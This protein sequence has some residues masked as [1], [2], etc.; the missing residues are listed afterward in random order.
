MPSQSGMFGD[1][2]GQRRLPVVDVTNGSNV[3][4]R[5]LP[6]KFLLSHLFYS[7]IGMF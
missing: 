4:M 1:C 6:L 3:H 5:L 2:S 7:S